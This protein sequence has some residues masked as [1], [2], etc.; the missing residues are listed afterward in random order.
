[1]LSPSQQEAQ[2]ALQVAVENV[3]RQSRRAEVGSSDI[4][5]TG[6]WLLISSVT[7]IDPEDQER[8]YVYHIAFSGGEQPE[9]IAYGLL[10]TAKGIIQN[11]EATG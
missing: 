10:E 2:D 1:M 3:V 9:H 7:V 11:G 5:I 4:E 6:D 8:R